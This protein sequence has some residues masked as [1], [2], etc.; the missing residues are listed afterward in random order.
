MSQ[1]FFNNIIQI[2]NNFRYATYNFCMLHKL[3]FIH[4]FI[5]NIIVINNSYNLI[6]NIFLKIDDFY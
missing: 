2:C 5:Q 4:S 3:V 6:L 1:D